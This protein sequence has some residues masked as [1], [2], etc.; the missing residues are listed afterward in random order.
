MGLRTYAME[1]GGE[2][3]QEHV[4]RRRYLN[5]GADSH[6]RLFGDVED[7]NTFRTKPNYM[8]SD[9]LGTG[10]GSELEPTLYKKRVSD[11]QLGEYMRQQHHQQQQE[12]SDEPDSNG[13]GTANAAGEGEADHDS[14]GTLIVI[15]ITDEQQS[16]GNGNGNGDGETDT[17]SVNAD[18]TELDT[19][20]VS[21]LDVTLETSPRNTSATSARDDGGNPVTGS[22]Y[23]EVSP[24]I[25]N[26]RRQFG[27]RQNVRS[28]FW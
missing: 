22:G 26:R 4:R 9:I 10:L 27:N 25:P 18:G 20:G 2:G 11:S 28:G 3:E 13:N 5:V 16:Q 14:M 19:T 12:E 24:G 6:S 17:G 8:K 15:E 1:K 7:G 23:R 21:S